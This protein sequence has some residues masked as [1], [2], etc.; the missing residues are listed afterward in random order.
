[1]VW[2]LHIGWKLRCLGPPEVLTQIYHNSV[3]KFE[4]QFWPPLEVRRFFQWY[5]EM[6]LGI[7]KRFQGKKLHYFFRDFNFGWTFQRL[8]QDREKNHTQTFVS[9]DHFPV[10]ADNPEVWQ[11]GITVLKNVAE[12][13]QHEGVILEINFGFLHLVMKY[14]LMTIVYS[15]M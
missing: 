4:P 12:N 1:M 15:S 14:N 10:S 8:L 9:V 13:W 3:K 6:V 11:S 2:H 7:L 5:Q